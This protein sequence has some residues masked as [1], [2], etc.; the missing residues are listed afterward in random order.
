MIE[1]LS[2][3]RLAGMILAAACL[4]AVIWATYVR[5]PALP[6]QLRCRVMWVCD[7]DTVWVR[8]WYGRRL[9][10]RLA[11]I[12]APESEQEFGEASQKVLEN[13]VGGRTVSVTVI[14]RDHYGRFVAGIECQGVDICL[15]MLEEGAAWPY[16]QYFRN[17]PADKAVAYREAGRAARIAGRGLWRNARAETPWDWRKRHRSLWARLLFWLRRL[18]KRLFRNREGAR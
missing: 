18:L 5:V 17:L 13:L 9:K 14:D 10:L 12:D 8:T 3:W 15:R 4:L 6:W 1:A 7:G 11:G 2:L 16:F